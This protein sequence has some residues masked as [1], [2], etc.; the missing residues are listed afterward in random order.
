MAEVKRTVWTTT[1][2]DTRTGNEPAPISKEDVDIWS[3]TADRLSSY[4]LL[5]LA[6]ALEAEGCPGNAKVEARKSD[7]GQL[8]SLRVS[9]TIEHPAPA[10]AT[11]AVATP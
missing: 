11:E 9:W 2:R 1:K 10:A 7:T 3:A 5:D 4:H 6:K 8:V